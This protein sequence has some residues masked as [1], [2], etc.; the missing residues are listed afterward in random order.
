MDSQNEKIRCR[1]E[2]RNVPQSASPASGASR[3]P[4]MA[5]LIGA[6]PGASFVVK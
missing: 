5:A 6:A 4:S 1:V 3:T 2:E